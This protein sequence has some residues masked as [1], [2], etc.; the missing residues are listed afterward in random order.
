[1]PE[2][3]SDVVTNT[4]DEPVT[5]VLSALDE[6]VDGGNDVAGPAVVLSALGEMVDGGDAVDEP[7]V[8]LSALVRAPGSG[9]GSATDAVVPPP[10]AQHASDASTPLT[11]YC[12]M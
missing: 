12:S 3:V 10:H 4:L 7:A 8:V 6:M 5:E 11:A 9:S 2:S 1:M